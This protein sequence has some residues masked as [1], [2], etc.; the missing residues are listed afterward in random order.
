MAGRDCGPQSLLPSLTESPVA[1]T[2]QAHG[3][4]VFLRTP[5]LDFHF[6]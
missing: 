3:V 4:T 6:C 1:R 5:T 2:I